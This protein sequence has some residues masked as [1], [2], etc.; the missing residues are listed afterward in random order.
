MDHDHYE[1]TGP[2]AGA[3]SGRWRATVGGID[4]RF[5]CGVLATLGEHAKDLGAERALVV[6][7]PGLVAAGHAEAAERALEAAGVRASVFDGAHENPTTDDVE[8]ATRA[9]REHRADLLIGLGGGSSM[10]CAKGANFLLAG[11]GPMEDYWGYGKARGR[12]L[13]SIGVPTT[14]GTG[15]EAQSF[16]LVSRVEDHVK[17]ACGDPQAR[18]R[19]VLLDPCLLASLPRSVA[20]VAA[21]DAVS[22]AIESYV[23]R[24]RNPMSQIFA[25]EAWRR[26]DRSFEAFLA[27]RADT[28]ACSDM[29]VGAH[30]AGGAIEASMLGAAHACANP[31]TAR[32]GTTHGVA[33]GLM[34]PHVVRYNA[35]DPAI[36]A[37]Y[38]DLLAERPAN[39][40]SAATVL[41]RR[42][43]ALGT[44]AGLPPN[45]AALGIA[46]T[47][48]PR[49]SESAAEQWT[50]KFNPRPVDS[51][52]AGALYQAAFDGATAGID[53]PSRTENA[54]VV[55]P[56]AA[57]EAV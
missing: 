43:V 19:I 1:S 52:A 16:A 21:L 3:D 50:G 8:A 24:R 6:T 51:A 2:G 7:D 27:D 29:L 53:E 23:T 49:L 22:H 55:P 25:R 4:V 37:L 17:M 28:D 47:D 11:G 33:V 56:E 48:L 35:I 13:P 41:S 34:L 45:L 15:S 18:F 5:G 36:E 31:L 39:G 20:A 46:S 38:G 32:F 12:L 42:L 57:R 40:A 44:V 9:A 54:A 26:L 10:D 14:A 30:F